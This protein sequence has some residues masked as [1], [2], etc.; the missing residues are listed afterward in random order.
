[1]RPACLWRQLFGGG[2]GW[3]AAARDSSAPVLLPWV[4][5]ALAAHGR[6]HGAPTLY[7]S[8]FLFTSSS[9]K[10]F[11]ACLCL[12]YRFILVINA[13]YDFFLNDCLGTLHSCRTRFPQETLTEGGL[14]SIL[15]ESLKPG[16]CPPRLIIS[17]TCPEVT[18]MATPHSKNTDFSPQK[19]TCRWTRCSS[20]AAGKPLILYQTRKTRRHKPETPH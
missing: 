2:L 18:L 5:Q 15:S 17:S 16:W 20:S 9:P 7:P 14:G 4:G 1:M 12:Y 6:T 10:Y 3:N 13:N 8:P 19:Q 11:L